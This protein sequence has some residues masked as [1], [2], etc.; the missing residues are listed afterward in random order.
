MNGNGGIGGRVNGNDHVNLFHTH[1]VLYVVLMSYAIHVILLALNFLILKPA[2]NPLGVS[3]M[4]TGAVFLIVG[5]ANLV[6]LNAHRDVRWW[7]LTG[8]IEVVMLMGFGTLQL[9]AVWQ[10]NQ[11]SAQSPGLYSMG[12]VPLFV[13]LAF[14]PYRNPATEKNGVSVNDVA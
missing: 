6:A 1:P 10:E 2:F 3:K 13:L 12:A 4:L 7:R 8:V 14:E 9:I 11:T 5:T